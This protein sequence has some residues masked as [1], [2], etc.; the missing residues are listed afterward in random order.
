MVDNILNK[1]LNKKKER[2]NELKK[3]I[4]IQSLQEKIIKNNFYMNFKEKIQKNISNDKISLIAEIKKASPSAG[5]IVKNY[6]PL[7]I[8]KRYN[9]KKVT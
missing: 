2:L 8:A 7:D 4:S 9:E 6:N 1:I 5:V 3:I